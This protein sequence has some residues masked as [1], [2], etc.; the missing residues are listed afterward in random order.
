M[1]EHSQSS[2]LKT[3]FAVWIALLAGTGLTYWAALI[4]LG[5]FN[6]ALALIIATT[7][8]LLVALFFM[9]LKGANEKLLKLVVASTLF[10]LILLLGLSM[11]DYGTRY[12]S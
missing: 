12:Y 8:A 6:S 3:Y 2:P 5:S 9:H 10:F 7:K 11:F 4:D 1:S